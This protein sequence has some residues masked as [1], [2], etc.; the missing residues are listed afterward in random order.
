[1]DARWHFLGPVQRNK[2]KA[3]APHVAL[4]HALDR[5]SPG[6]ELLHRR[7]SAQVLVQVNISGDPA[8]PGASWSDAPELVERLR[9]AGLDVRGLMGVASV[10]GARQQFRRL[11]RLRDELGLEELSMGMSGDLEVAV[12]EG[13]TM[14]RVGTALFGP[15]PEAASVR[16]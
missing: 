6:T 4:W 5:V 16:R 13:A 3:L 9:G 12:E 1:V 14:V 8:R 2:V 10:D 15:R 7:A 11:A